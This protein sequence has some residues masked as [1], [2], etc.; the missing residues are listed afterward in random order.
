ME[1]AV[2]ANAAE[3][4]PGAD[5]G[6]RDVLADPPPGGPRATLAHRSFQN[7]STELQFLVPPSAR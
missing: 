4:R 2:R 6:I 7:V 5:A 3:G 1:T